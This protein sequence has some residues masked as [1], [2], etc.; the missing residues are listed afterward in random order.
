MS[1]DHCSFSST[2][3]QRLSIWAKSNKRIGS[4]LTPGK[5]LFRFTDTPNDP[6][7]ATI[8]VD[9]DLLSPKYRSKFIETDFPNYCITLIKALENSIHFQLAADP[10]QY[11]IRYEFN[12]QKRMLAKHVVYVFG[13]MIF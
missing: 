6:R 11:T 10:E 2:F 7:G 3:N 5:N 9:L 1:R 12:Y 8:Y 13:A 4:A